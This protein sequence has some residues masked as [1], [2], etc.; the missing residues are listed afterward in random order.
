MPAY[1]PVYLNLKGKRCLVIGGGRV[2]ESKIIQL[3]AAGAAVSV[4]SPEVTSAIEESAQEGRLDWQAREY[5]PGDL[6]GVFLG[7]AATNQREV[8]QQIYSEAER[9]GVLLNVVD[10]PERCTFIAPS[11]VERGPVTVA[12]STGGTSP[13]L[14]RKLREILAKDPALEWAD[15]AGVMSQARKEVKKR[16]LNVDRQRWQCCLTPELL[17]LAQEGREDEALSTLLS[18]LSDPGTPGLCSRVDH[19]APQGCAT[20]PGQSTVE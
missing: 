19:C 16:R 5:K 11:I 15:L 4:I 8:N 12:I 17:K 3:Q 2:A 20:Q 6:D 1:Y 18:G 7:I 13:A 10:D 9:K 14:A